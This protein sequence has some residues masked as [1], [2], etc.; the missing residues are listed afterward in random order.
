[1]NFLTQQFIADPIVLV[2][3]LALRYWRVVEFTIFETGE[4]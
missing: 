4:L 2:F 3:L 1:M